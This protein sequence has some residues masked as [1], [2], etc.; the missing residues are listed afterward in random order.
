MNQF[1]LPIGDWSED[2]HSESEN[3]TVS[4][5]KT[6]HELIDAY[7]ETAKRL[8]MTFAT[9]DMAEL[10]PIRLLNKWGDSTL[11]ADVAKQLRAGGVD[12]SGITDAEINEAGDFKYCSPKDAAHLFMAFIKAS[13]PDLTWSFVDDD[14]IYL[15][16]YWGELNISVGYGCFL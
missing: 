6:K 1:I 2:G 5:N 9:N 3:F 8:N 7:H 11:T 14:D 4:V 15:F 10:S 13:L 16:G 12:L